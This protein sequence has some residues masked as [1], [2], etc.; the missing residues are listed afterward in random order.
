MDKWEKE[1]LTKRLLAVTLVI[2]LLLSLTACGQNASGKQTNDYVSNDNPVM[3]NSGSDS[4]N[5]DVDNHYLSDTSSGINSPLTPGESDGSYGGISV[6]AETDNAATGHKVT[7]WADLSINTKNFDADYQTIAT[8]VYQSGG[9]VSTE[10]Y[11]DESS[12][13]NTLGRHTQLTVKVP[14]TGFDSFL[15]TISEIGVVTSLNRYSEDLTASYYDTEARIAML[16]LRKERLMGYLLDAEKA[17]DIVA[18]ERELSSVLADLDSLQS[19]KRLYDQL[20][21]Y[22]TIDINLVELIT[23]ETI[24]K[25]GE[26]LGERASDA[27]TRSMRDLRLFF[28]D[29][30]VFLAGAAPVIILLAVVGLIVWLIVIMIRSSFRAYRKSASYQAKQKR[31]QAARQAAYLQ[32][33]E[34]QIQMQKAYIQNQPAPQGQPIQS[35]Q[36]PVPSST[37]PL[38]QQSPTE[39]SEETDTPKQKSSTTDE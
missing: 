38:E 19:D 4:Y 29:A 2:A 30:V 37:V 22:S 34:Q 14:A 6:N 12:Y 18:F 9:Y 10:R 23:P 32:A 24:G 7:F 16:E 11:T 25:D 8:M 27:F 35:D 13:S 20:V 1:R 15:T 28:E 17:E 36:L 31:Q 33:Q 39:P 5:A 21:D 26:P 3:L